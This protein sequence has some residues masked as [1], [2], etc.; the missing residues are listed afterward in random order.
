MEADATPLIE[1]DVCLGRLG[2]DRV[3]RRHELLERDGRDRLDERRARV[4]PDVALR[5]TRSLDHARHV[6]D[7]PEDRA[8]EQQ[9]NVVG[10]ADLVLEEGIL[11][12]QVDLAHRHLV[13][14]L[15][16]VAH[17]VLL[18]VLLGRGR[19]PVHGHELAVRRKEEG[20]AV[21]GARGV[22]RVEVEGAEVVAHD[23][24]LVRLHAHQPAH[25]DDLLER[26]GKEEALSRDQPLLAARLGEHQHRRLVVDVDRVLDAA[27][28]GLLV[29][30][31]E[32]GRLAALDAQRA[33]RL[34]E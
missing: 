26:L 7:L 1:G 25:L 12:A 27:L 30:A 9:L 6:G 33:R 19:R 31:R 13:R 20:R 14:D 21:A 11:C 28:G 32:D 16:G 34:V 29:R 23:G 3:E 4:V 17:D 2:D 15:L 5:V 8:F 24:D 10:R 22:A 18:G